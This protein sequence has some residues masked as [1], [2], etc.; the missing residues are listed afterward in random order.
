MVFLNNCATSPDYP[1]EPEIGFQSFSK[2]QLRQGSI[3][4]DSTFLT[5]TFKDGD[6]DLG[7]DDSVLETNLF[8]TDNR[9]GELFNQYKT[10]F[11]PEEGIGNGI[12]GEMRILL[13]TTCCTFPDNIPPCAAPDLYPTNEITFDIYIVDRAGNKSNTLTTPPLTL[14]C[15]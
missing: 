7:L 1:D 8:L 10:P 15:N 12:E 9:T 14:L 3:N 13:F 2:T 4:N 11:I 6:G 5:I